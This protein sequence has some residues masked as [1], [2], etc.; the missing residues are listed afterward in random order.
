MTSIEFSTTKAFAALSLVAAL[1]AKAQT[2]AGVWCASTSN[3]VYN[4]QTVNM[5]SSSKRDMQKRQTSGAL[6]W[7]I[8]DGIVRDAAGRKGYIAE[9][10]QFQFDNEV[11]AGAKETGGFEICSNNSLAVA[12]S[13]IF[14]QCRSGEFYNLYSQSISAQC[15]PIHIQALY[16]GPYSSVSASTR[17]IQSTSIRSLNSSGS[18]T[19]SVST[20]PAATATPPATSSSTAIA[21]PNWGLSTGAKAGIGV[22]VTLLV[23]LIAVVAVLLF[24]LKN[25]KKRMREMA[26]ISAPNTEK[27]IGVHEQKYLAGSNAQE[28]SGEDARFELGQREAAEMDLNV[29]PQELDSRSGN[30]G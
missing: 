21:P 12:G 24:R 11:Q 22:G 8:S 7:S 2:S 17:S 14:Y 13:T 19:V 3:G 18:P 27:P 5:T 1:V 16:V 20:S 23:I 10:Y 25:T 9:N 28:V 6:V 4:M 15:I 29:A 30:R 26:S